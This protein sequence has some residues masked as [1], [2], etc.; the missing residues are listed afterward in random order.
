MTGPQV[1]PRADIALMDGYHSPQV[2][3]PVRLNTNECPTPPPD[4]WVDA[5]RDELAGLAWNRYP[6]RAATDLR[7][8]LADLH[9]VDP[10]QI[11]AAN[12][13]NEVLQSLCLAY[14][15]AGRAVATFEPTYALHGHIARVTG[16]D[17]RT[18]DRDEDFAIDPGRLDDALADGPSILFL[19]SPNNP[20]GRVDPESLVRRAVQRCR[21]DGVLLVVDEAYGQFSPWSALDLVDDD[22]SVVVCRT[23]SKTWAMAGGRL[24]YCVAPTW[25][26]DQLEKVV[27]PY[28]L[29]LVTQAAGRLAL[30]HREAMLSRVE[31]IVAER[32]RVMEAF[33]DLPVTTW[34][35]GANFVLFRPDERPGADVWQDQHE[36]GPRRPGGDRQVG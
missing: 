18:Y 5:L 15:G 34:P 23:F 32:N 1:E 17:V 27:L 10:R 21:E 12:G 11:F 7:S 4:E 35:S 22:H 8:A 16:A 36:V 19:C 31:A 9:G 13:S 25:V 24:G 28:H 30:E 26:V 6:D 14:G 2:D 20:T 3:V 33:A 29:D